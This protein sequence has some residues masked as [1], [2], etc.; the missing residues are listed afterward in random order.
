M[1]K[2]YSNVRFMKKTISCVYK[3]LLLSIFLVMLLWGGV[4]AQNA[5][6]SGKITSSSGES[7]P[8][9][10]VVVKGTQIGIISNSEGM[11]KISAPLNGTLVFSFIGFET[12]QVQ[13]KGKTKLDIVLRESTIGLEEVVAIGYGTQKKKE[14]TGAVV[15]VSSDVL[16]RSSSIDLGTALQ[17]QVAGVNVQASSGRPGDDSNIQIRGLNSVTGTNA[18]LF[19]VDGIPYESNPRLS[20]S[21][22]ET[23]DVLKDAASAAI[24]GTRGSG[25]VILITTKK[26]KVGEMKISL[27]S[28][29][30]IQKITSG[31]P[32]MN[33]EESM[34]E[35][36]IVAQNVNNTNMSTS[37]TY[38][39]SDRYGFTNN[40]FLS[41]VLENNNAPIQSHNL[42]ISGGKQDLTYNIVASYFSQE[43]MMLHSGYDRFNVRANTSYKKGR[44]AINTGIGIRVENQQYEPWQLLLEAYKYKPYQQAIDPNANTIQDAGPYGSNQQINLG[45]MMIKLKQTDVRDGDNFSGNLQADYKIN[46]NFTYTGR[47]GINYSDN[48][49]VRIN[50]LFKTYDSM[51]SL[52]PMTE[53]SAVYNA[54]DRSNSFTFE[55]SLNFSKRFGNHQLKVLGLFSMEKYVYTSFWAQK[56]DLVSNDIT[57]LNG[58][59]LDP[60]AGSGAGW[61]QDRTNSLIGILGRVQYDYKGRYLLSVSARHDGSSRF[62]EKYRWGT[63]PSASIGWNVADEKFWSSIANMING[64]K[65]RG[66]YGTTGNQNFLDY[67]NSASITLARDYVMGPESGDK[68]ILGATQTAFANQNVKWETTVQRNIGIDLAFFKSKLTFTGD[69]YNTDKKD[70][71]FPILLPPSTGVGQNATVILNVGDMNNKGIEFASNYRHFGE[72]SWSVGGTFSKNINNITKMS[73]ANKTSYMSGG[74]V[75]E[76]VPNVDRVTVLKEGYEAGAF[77]VMPT[78]G[79]VKNADELA[80]YKT[81]VPT[82][83]LGDLRY[84]DTNIDGKLDDKDRVYAGSGAPEFELGLN[85]SFD[86]K[87]F[88]FSMQWYGSFGNNVINGSKLYSYMFGTNKD[89]IYQWSPQ[90]T[91][92]VISADRGRDHANARG[93]TDI[94]VEDGTFVRLRNLTLGYSLPAILIKKAGISKLRVYIAAQNPLTI[95]KYDGFDPEVGND[96][97]QSRGLDRGSYPISSQ[98]RVGIQLDF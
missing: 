69:Y 50:P 60:N 79:L 54:S 72:F 28:Y 52:M 19:V 83:K 15:Q 73:G 97:L 93:Y 43:G 71:L 53:R 96:G 85:L 4:Y 13:V 3:K 34:Y 78:N 51:G 41:K 35:T 90:N 68:L 18:P 31:V 48:K 92:A 46:K 12:I 87:R 76:G 77:F 84:V 10:N 9:V 38:L 55:N 56:F 89:L 20:T 33:F 80:I 8:G 22:I 47:V 23:V 94:W 7:I 57:V 1:L 67:S 2:N 42:T 29:Y 39:E 32:L 66:S 65:I 44:W 11:Y 24:Y 62:S 58:A 59:T 86:Y 88:D 98:Y 21:E 17:G 81:L 49:R 82:A 70:M 40:T 37:W 64:F 36:F 25:G 5:T 61:G 27:D 16:S 30:G 91:N 45:N 6:V 75:A 63:F 26:G 95:T 74:T 14:I